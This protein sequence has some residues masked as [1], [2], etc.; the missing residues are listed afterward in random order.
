[1]SHNYG[2]PIQEWTLAKLCGSFNT[3]L[4]EGNYKRSRL[5][6]NQSDLNQSRLLHEIFVPSYLPKKK[7]TG[8][9]LNCSTLC[10]SLQKKKHPVLGDS[11]FQ[12]PWCLCVTE[13]IRSLP[14]SRFLF[15]LHYLLNLQTTH[16]L[17]KR[18]L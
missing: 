2:T 13:T 1:V 17:I 7:S 14:S 12:C 8:G 4:L 15:N 11:M 5:S 10:V 9:M 18:S 3:S 6:T 16:L